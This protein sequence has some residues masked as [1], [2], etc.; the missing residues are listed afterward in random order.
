VLKE[1]C[2]RFAPSNPQRRICGQGQ[3]VFP[4]SRSTHSR[5]RQ[6]CWNRERGAVSDS[7]VSLL[8]LPKQ[9]PLRKLNAEG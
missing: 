4:G 6:G 5:Y 1:E 3:R 8:G 7:E 2:R 9:V